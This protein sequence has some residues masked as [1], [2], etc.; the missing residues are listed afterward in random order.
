[1]L[2]SIASCSDDDDD[3]DCSDDIGDTDDSDDDDDDETEESEPSTTPAR[4]WKYGEP[5]TLPNHTI[6][7]AT[8][9]DRIMQRDRLLAEEY[10]YKLHTYKKRHEATSKK[11][12]IFVLISVGI[13]F[14]G[15]LGFAFTV[16]VRMLTSLQ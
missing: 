11:F 15:I 9:R 5:P 14:V 1:V 8:K 2:I 12:R 6:H 4:V 7:S 13:I 3:G 10:D 16:C